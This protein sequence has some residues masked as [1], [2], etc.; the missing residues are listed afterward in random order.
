LITSERVRSLQVLRGLAAC[1]VV[2]D[3]AVQRV[4]LVWHTHSAVA[5]WLSWIGNSG[6][7][8][9]FVLS[10]F[11]MA[12]LHREQFGTHASRRF[13]VR[14]IVRIAP[15][16]W[17]LNAVAMLLLIAL[18]GTFSNAH[19]V[20]W[21]WTLGNFLFLPLP[22]PSGLMVHVITVGWTL[23]YEMYFYV[24]F[25][26]AML[27]RRGLAL[28]AAF[29][30]ASFTLGL[31]VKFHQPWLVLL[32]NNLLLE[33]LAG[34]GI[35]LLLPRLRVPAVIG[36]ILLFGGLA[37]LSLSDRFDIGHRLWTFGVPCALILAGCL[38]I[39]FRCDGFVGRKLVTVGDASYSIY[40]FQAFALPPA[41]YVLRLAGMERLP[42]DLLA[43]LI[44]ILGCAAGMLCWALLEK[45]I[46]NWLRRNVQD[47]FRDPAGRPSAVRQS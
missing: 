27:F 17:V 35:A 10:G 28:L 38:I 5:A 46:T 9:F 36:W 21:S 14:R 42:P 45:P 37:L 6:V 31:V 18:P 43:V 26:L 39:G 30:L 19:E 24:L 7:D 1:A 4:D 8:L 29:L 25:A 23:D 2:Y 13:L 33:F 34:I 40:L 15:L 12:H 20:S 22:R 44:A 3:H 47:R 16:Y 11:L 32:T 41:A